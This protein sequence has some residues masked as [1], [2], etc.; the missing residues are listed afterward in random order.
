MRAACRQWAQGLNLRV[1]VMVP[2][3]MAVLSLRA[4]ITAHMVMV[5]LN[6][7]ATIMA[8]MAV[9][10]PKA[11]V[12]GRMATEVPRPKATATVVPSL[13]VMVMKAPSPRGIQ[14]A[15]TAHRL[16]FNIRR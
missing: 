15:I 1:M 3:V 2:M 6:L 13:K 16:A 10:G 4:T 8:H 11:T 14:A 7:R 9:L 12:M 5:V